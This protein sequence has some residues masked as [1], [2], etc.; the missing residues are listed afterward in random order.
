[1]VKH[2]RKPRR[3]A[4]GVALALVLSAAAP[5]IAEA[6]GWTGWWGSGVELFGEW[7]RA[8]TGISPSRASAESEA[9]P[10]IDPNGPPVGLTDP[11]D[12]LQFGEADDNTGGQTEASP[13]IDP[14]G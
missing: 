11:Q 12:S 14:D 10:E 6:P 1:M 3:L 4:L 7:W 2:A 8:I 9:S 5:A 13:E